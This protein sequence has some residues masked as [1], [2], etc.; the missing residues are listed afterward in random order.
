MRGIS[1]MDYSVYV[2]K[3][4]YT[5]TDPQIICFTNDLIGIHNG[6]YTGKVQ[7]HNMLLYKPIVSGP[8][9]V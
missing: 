6:I 5:S 3:I 1:I 4:H 8:I 9:I 7:C 2:H